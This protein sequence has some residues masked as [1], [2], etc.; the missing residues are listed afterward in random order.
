MWKDG[1]GYAI[2]D[3]ILTSGIVVYVDCY[4]AQGGDLGGELGKSRVVLAVMQVQ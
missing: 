1:V 4:A 2:L 3:N